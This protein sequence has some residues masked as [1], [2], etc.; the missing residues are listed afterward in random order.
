M[1]T[2]ST[3]KEGV[4]FEWI[5]FLTDELTRVP[6]AE[7]VGEITFGFRKKCVS[8][9]VSPIWMHPIKAAGELQEVHVD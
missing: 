3:K 4:Y 9:G 7:N 5:K 8:V 1:R 6:Q 2:I